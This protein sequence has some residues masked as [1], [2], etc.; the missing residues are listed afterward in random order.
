MAFS[1]D[2]ENKSKRVSALADINVTP[3]VDILLVLLIIFMVAAPTVHHGARLA[4]PDI[5]PSDD[6]QPPPKED[7]KDTLV[8]DKEGK[9]KF[10]GKEYK[11]KDL[12]ALIK[13]DPQLKKTRELYLQADLD[14]PYGR[15]ME[16]IGG[17]RRAGIKKLGVV[18]NA[19][20][21]GIQPT[22]EDPPKKR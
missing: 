15:V 21:L 1:S 5:T 20:E 10:R 7:E 13:A 9:L 14:L 11:L 12:A 16:V 8:I 22:P 17:V 6:K 18:V 19:D 4:A 3:L 2:N